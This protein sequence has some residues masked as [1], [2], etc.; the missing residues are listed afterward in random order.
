MSLVF[1]F[2]VN[3]DTLIEEKDLNISVIMVTVTKEKR[4]ISMSYIWSFK[5][6]C[7]LSCKVGFF[8]HIG[9]ICR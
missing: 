8:C 5:D 1:I 3:R 4:H 7:V 9:A 6:S 2:L